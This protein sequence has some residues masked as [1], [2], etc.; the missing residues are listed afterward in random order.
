MYT[1]RSGKLIVNW[2]GG[3]GNNVVKREPALTSTPYTTYRRQLSAK[4]EIKYM[5][6][7]DIRNKFSPV[8]PVGVVMLGGPHKNLTPGYTHHSRF[9]CG[10]CW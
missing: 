9:S 4:K 2:F 7:R 10:L 6:T 3:I 5:V 1:V 8:L